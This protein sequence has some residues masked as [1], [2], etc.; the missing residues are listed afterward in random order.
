MQAVQDVGISLGTEGFMSGA[1]AAARRVTGKAQLLRAGAEAEKEAVE[2]LA[3]KTASAEAGVESAQASVN[4]EIAKH[5]GDALSGLKDQEE[6]KL[7]DAGLGPKPVTIEALT[8]ATAPVQ[9]ATQKAMQSVFT[10][11]SDKW[12]AALSKYDTLPVQ[13]TLGDAA[14][15]IRMDMATENKA[16]SP[17]ISKLLKQAEFPEA[18]AHEVQSHLGIRNEFSRVMRESKNPTDRRIAARMVD[19]I[20]DDV[21]RVVPEEA[22]AQLKVLRDEWHQARSTF[23]NA[24]RSRLFRASSPEQVAEA[25][26]TGAK[27]GKAMSHRASLVLHQIATESHARRP[28]LRS[29]FATMAASDPKVI[30]NMDGSLFKALFPGTGFDDPK[31]WKEALAGSVNTQKI[32]SSPESTAR[33]NSAYQQGMSSLGVKAKEA[34]LAE[35]EKAL[36]D[37]PSK[38]SV[39]TEA[40]KKGG[41][42]GMK[43]PILGKRFMSHVENRI[44]FHAMLSTAA[45]TSYHHSVSAAWGAPL[46]Y[47]AVSK[48]IG[49][50]LS[51]PTV[52]KYYYKALTSKSAEQMGFWFGRATTA[53]LS[54]H[55]RESLDQ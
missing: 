13:S 46:A 4:K 26:Y 11:I 48:A 55:L 2:G 45:F 47:M 18:A 52:G 35:A 44:V 43:E 24:F 8:Q 3:K 12:D 10:G 7:V 19:A 5:A 21:Q 14:S 30:D 34:A 36:R 41:M 50:F 9:K 33:F 53:A 25:L 37:L 22:Q 40:F 42:E 39:M 49:A 38:Q 15:A 6:E 51:N 31:K 28:M 27:T 20:D 1:G 17:S 23:S 29:S 16:I 32:L 54:Q